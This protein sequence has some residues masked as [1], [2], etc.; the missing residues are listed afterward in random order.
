[1]DSDGDARGPNGDLPPNSS[2]FDGLELELF[3]TSPTLADTDGDG[4]TDFEEANQVG[5]HPLIA[6]VPQA[7]VDLV[8]GVDLRLAITET[9]ENG[10]SAGRA[11]TRSQGSTSGMSSTYSSTTRTSV[12]A[13]VAI[14]TEAEV[15]FPR[16]AR[17]S[18][19]LMASTTAGYFQEQSSSFS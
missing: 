14:T 2:F 7:R 6:D 11:T 12:E 18:T 15:G 3:G 16:G 13:T 9:A 1:M 19:S 4:L 10:Q 17:A 5:S 8:G